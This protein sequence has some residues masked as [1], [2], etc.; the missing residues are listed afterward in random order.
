M[1]KFTVLGDAVIKGLLFDLSK[2][3]IV[4]FL[5][6]LENCLIAYSSGNERQYQPDAGIVNRPNGQKILFR[7][8]T[9]PDTV[10]AKIVVHPAPISGGLET[11]SETE[12]KP[13]ASKQTQQLPLHGSMVLCDQ[14]GHPKGFL[15][16]EEVT[17]YRTALSA[18]IPY[19]SRLRTSSIVVFGAGKQALWH[20]RLALALRGAEITSVTVVNRSEARGRELI[21]SL[22]EENG[23]R[24]NSPCEFDLLTFSQEGAQE[25]LQ[26]RLAEADVI[27]CTVAS[28]NPL[29]SLESL[30]LERRQGTYP[31]ITAVGSWQSDMIE[32]HP[33][34]IRHI[35]GS[36]DFSANG[37]TNGVILVDDAKAA[38]THS[39][40]VVQS[41]LTMVHML[42]IGNILRSKRNSDLTRD[43]TAWLAEGL[44]V[45]KSIG[46]SSTDLVAGNY[47]LALAEKKNLRTEVTGF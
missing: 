40:E 42:E 22:K 9:S 31:L 39:G 6:E 26:L 16:A 4:Y 20:I 1:A 37:S 46:V 36:K 43:Q 8:F 29:F 5:N 35:I 45:Y 47:I 33:A 14:S 2:D 19:A 38:L 17:G 23:L 34:I 12:K 11:S 7:P 27:F 15:N 32:V 18:M 10:G 30:A 21:K 24:W 3:E 25:K 28:Q 44:I 41:G 13:S